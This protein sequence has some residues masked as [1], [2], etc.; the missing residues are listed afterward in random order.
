MFYAIHHEAHEGPAAEDT[1][2]ANKTSEIIELDRNASLERNWAPF[3]RH[4][5]SMGSCS[6]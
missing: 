3:W 1:Y 6:R 5:Y 4:F 2:V